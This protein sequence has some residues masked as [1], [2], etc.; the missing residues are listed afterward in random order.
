MSILLTG[1]TEV[2]GLTQA[3]TDLMG[4]VTTMVD[5]M[6]T[7]KLAIFFYAAVAFIAIKVVRSLKKTA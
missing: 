2:G 1:T 5:T 6:S 4:A 7:G 3:M